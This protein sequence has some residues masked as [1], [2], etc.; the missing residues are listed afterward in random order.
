MLHTRK[1]TQ[2]VANIEDNILPMTMASE[3]GSSLHIAE[4][5]QRSLAELMPSIRAATSEIDDCI[6]RAEI[7]SL[8]GDSQGQKD[9]IINELTK[10]KQKFLGR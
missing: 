10:I 1:L 7:L 8:N 9:L 3:M 4:A 2:S 5:Y 6:T